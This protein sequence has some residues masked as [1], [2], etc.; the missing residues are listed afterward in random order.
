VERLVRS[1]VALVGWATLGLA[2]VALIG[3]QACSAGGSSKD[4]ASK[5]SGGNGVSSSSNGSGGLSTTGSGGGET[6][7]ETTAEAM[8]GVLPADILFVVDNS[9]SMS[10]EAG[11]VQQSMNDFSNIVFGSGI[12][13]H[14]ILISADSSDDHG[15]CVPTPLGSGSCPADEKL[16]TYQHVAVSV[17]SSNSLQLVLDTYP[18]YQGSLR[19]GASKTIAVISDDNSA[20]S[21]ADFTAQLLALDPT[22]VDFKFHAI[23]APYEVN[24]LTCFSCSPP[25]CAACDPCCGV[26]S[27]IGIVCNPLPADEGVVY[28]ELVQQTM[29]TLGDLC[30][31]NFQ[32]VFQAMATA[33]IASSQVPCVYDIP[34]DPGGDTIDFGKVNVSYKADDNAAEEVIANV[35]GGLPDCDPSGGWYY[36]DPQ[37]PTKIILCPASCTHFQESSTGS[38]SVKFGC[39]TVVK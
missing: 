20:L 5:G 30:T 12:D 14:V 36:D 23:V 8:E 24:P 9:G 26:N 22:F 4:S 19:T 2:Y 28:K 37:S 18:Q 31:Q 27:S 16:P 38:V 13:A 32:P 6:C 39:T 7:G 17:G 10:D 15:I 25:N 34:P 35:P 1:K 21:A 11:F 29:G 33:V 3:S